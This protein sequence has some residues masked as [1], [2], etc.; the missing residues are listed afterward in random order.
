MEATNPA[1]RR[2]NQNLLANASCS[3][4]IL[5]D[6]SLSGSIRLAANEV[7]HQVAVLFFG[8]PDDREALPYGWRMSEHPGTSLTV[9]RFVPGEDSTESTMH[10]SSD[11]NDPRMLTMETDNSR[12]KQLDDEYINDFWMKKEND[13]SVIYT[14]KVVNNGEETVATIRTLDSSHDLFIVGR[15]QGMISTLT[16]GL[17]DWSECLELGAIG[18]ILASSDFHQRYL[19]W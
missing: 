11:Q 7:F 9:L 14:E 18:E 17:T 3:V 6:R 10:P 1:F 12:E 4:G 8:G 16:S 19:C 2:V 13:E 15:G 5:V